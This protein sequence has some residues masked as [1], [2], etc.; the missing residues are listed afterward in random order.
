MTLGCCI[1]EDEWSLNISK[2][3][4]IAVL[5]YCGVRRGG[6]ERIT[7]KRTGIEQHCDQDEKGR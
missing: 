1:S 6:E 4:N 7:G 3:C 2:V 5:L